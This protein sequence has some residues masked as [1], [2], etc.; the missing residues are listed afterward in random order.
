[1]GTAAIANLQRIDAFRADPDDLIIVEDPKHPLYDERVKLPLDENLVLNIMAH[2]VKVPVLGRKN[3]DKVEVVDGRQR[4]RAAREAN[5]RLKKQGSEPVLVKIHIERG[6]DADLFGVTVLANELRQNDAPLTRAKKAQRLLDMGKSEEEVALILGGKV[7][8]LRQLLSLLDTSAAVQ[9]AVEQ[10]KVG[11]VAASKL[12]KLE[13]AEQDKALAKL[14]TAAADGKVK[15]KAARNVV[16]EAQGKAVS[17][18]P[19]KREIRAV[20]E[21]LAARDDSAGDD[22]SAPE[23]GALQALRW[24]LDGTSNAFINDLVLK[25]NQRAAD[26]GD[27]K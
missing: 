16:A 24:V 19:S 6:T 5:R 20:V 15:G 17:N 23:S 4:V 21:H 9:R 13:R 12:A 1:M 2:G 10:G 11:I 3:G 27:E 8:A 7:A 25:A 18:A 14:T 22:L 26:A